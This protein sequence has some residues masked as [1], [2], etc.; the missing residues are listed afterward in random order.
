[1]EAARTLLHHN[2]M[3]E[4]NPIPALA[5]RAIG[6]RLWPARHALRGEGQTFAGDRASAAYA[7]PD[8]LGG[9]N[10]LREAA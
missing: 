2:A 9:S 6:V 4:F 10:G 7:R 3:I 8:V 5:W 1:M